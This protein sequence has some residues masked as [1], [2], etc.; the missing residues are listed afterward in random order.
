MYVKNSKPY[1]INNA[2]DE[3]KPAID[4]LY[5]CAIVLLEGQ[6]PF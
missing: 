4:S 2:S 5:A 3:N 6:W 1:H